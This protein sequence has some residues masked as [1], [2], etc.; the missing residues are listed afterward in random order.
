MLVS[1]FSVPF[2]TFP[3]PFSPFSTLFPTILYTPTVLTG[4]YVGVLLHVALLVE[5]LAAVAAGIRPRVAVYE[6][7]RGEGAGALEALAALFAL[8]DLLHVMHGPV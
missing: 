1:H 6:Q 8:K 3:V 7:M 5:S 4:V 2:S